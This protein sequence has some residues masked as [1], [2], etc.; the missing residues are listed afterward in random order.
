MGDMSRWASFTRPVTSLLQE[1]LASGVKSVPASPVYGSVLMR[2]GVHGMPAFV[3]QMRV[4]HP[5][6]HA[7]RARREEYHRAWARN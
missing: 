6:G 5:H 7:F 2:S 3:E 4:T 1:K